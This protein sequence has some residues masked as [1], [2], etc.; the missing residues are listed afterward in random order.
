MYKSE[1]HTINLYDKNYKI[2]KHLNK[3]HMLQK[4]MQKNQHFKIEFI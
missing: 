1:I 2:S 3:I 4:N